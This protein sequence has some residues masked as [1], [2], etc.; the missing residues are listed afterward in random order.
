M[1]VRHEEDALGPVVVPADALYGSQTV[2]SLTNL[3]FS[4]R[5]LGG[6][7]ELV[8]ALAVVKQAAARA[9]RQA[10][11]LPRKLADAIEAAALGLT[12]PEMAS[13]LPSDVLGGGGWIGV[14]MNVNEVI[15]NLAN[16]SFG[17]PLGAEKPIHP[18]LHVNASQSTADVCH[19]ASR[20]A[21]LTR[22][23]QLDAVLR[24]TVRSLARFVR[25]RGSAATLARTCLRDGLPTEVRVLFDGHREAIE[26]QRAE[27]QTHVPVF[28][29]VTLGGTVIGTGSGAPP[30]YR[31]RVVPLLAELTGERLTQR[32]GLADALQNSDDVGMYSA[33]L[34]QLARAL[35]K[36]AQDLRLLGSGPDGGFGE[37]IVPH[38]QQGSSFFAGKSNP[39]VPETMIQCCLQVFGCD[40]AAQ[41]AVERA[42]LHLN[43]FDSVAAINTLDAV[44]MLTAATDRFDRLCLAGLEIDEERCAMLAQAVKPGGKAKKGAGGARQRRLRD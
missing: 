18:K 41:A 34:A 26:R 36:L 20:L 15:A 44:A 38:V 7:P 1:A 5:P 3:S 29:A 14:H 40:H 17:K 30:A 22:Q 32:R 16:R 6:Y 27:L 8:A 35:L 42:E 2:R 13:H 43:V 28:R 37:V 25:R 12:A 4:G 9:N 24:R 21:L 33:R 23:R 39:V 31:R 10:G 19:T 11:V